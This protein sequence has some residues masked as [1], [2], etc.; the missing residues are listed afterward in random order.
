M[1]PDVLPPLLAFDL[2][3]TLLPDGAQEASPEMLSACAK[4]RGR[5]ALLA[6]VTGRVRLPPGLAEAVRPAAVATSNG[7]RVE[8]GGEV[9]RELHF[10]E[11]ELRRVLAFELPQARVMAY[12]ADTY[13]GG[14]PEQLAATQ[15]SYRP[16]DEARDVGKITFVHPEAASHVERMR[17]LHGH[18]VL[19]GAHPPYEQFLTVTPQGADKGAALALLA[20]EL[21][22]PL[23]RVAAFGDS[24]NDLTMLREAGFAVQVGN[25]PLL[26]P[27]ARAHVASQTELAAYLTRLAE[28]PT[29]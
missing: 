15:R 1:L 21:G 7:G 12:G 9:K 29:T 25:L 28:L 27:H 20:A 19:T 4:L 3:G 22:V 18:L 5:G 10:S 23:S 6:L 24:D 2:D 16:L 26:R 8:V 14:P 11:E 13:A 17:G